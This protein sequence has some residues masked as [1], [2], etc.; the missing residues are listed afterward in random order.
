MIHFV[1]SQ[2][3]A[4]TGHML[5][6]APWGRAWRDRVRLVTYPELFRE[7]S[8][9]PGTY[10]FCDTEILD[11]DDKQRAGELRAQLLEQGIADRV[12]N[13]PLK[14]LNRLDFLREMHARGVN[15]FNAWPIDEQPPDDAFPVFL[16]IADAHKGAGSPLLPQR[17]EL[18]QAVAQLRARSRHPQGWIIVQFVDTADESGVYPQVFRV[19]RRRRRDRKAT[20]FSAITG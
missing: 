18:E 8:H 10:L 16:R 4:V 2:W 9:R 17:A 11:R 15:P 6:W 19:H 12:F 1:T 7:R 14:N 20:C 13:D 5:V 3:N